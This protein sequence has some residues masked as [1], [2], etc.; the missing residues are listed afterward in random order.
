MIQPWGKGNK[1]PHDHLINSL[2]LSKIF[3]VERRF[4]LYHSPN[5]NI[6]DFPFHF[7]SLNSQETNTLFLF[8]LWKILRSLILSLKWETSF[9]VSA[10]T[11]STSLVRPAPATPMPSSSLRR[12]PRRRC[13]P[14]SPA[15][16]PPR[17]SWWFQ[18]HGRRPTLPRAWPSISANLPPP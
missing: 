11:P 7:P 14:P 4:L 9:P 12:L 1:S 13:K 16:T 5:K 8:S 3:S 18:W 17:I 6:S 10:K 2:S 15:S